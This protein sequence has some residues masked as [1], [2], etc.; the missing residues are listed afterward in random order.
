MI[1]KVEFYPLKLKIS[2]KM[3]V[4]HNDDDWESILKNL[5]NAVGITLIN[6]D[7]VSITLNGFMMENIEDTD[8]GIKQKFIELYKG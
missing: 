6:I 1:K 2:F 8:E 7:G 5:T 4:R 3:I